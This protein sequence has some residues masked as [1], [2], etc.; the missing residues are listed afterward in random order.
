MRGLHVHPLM[1]TLTNTATPRRSYATNRVHY[2]PAPR[3]RI[4]PPSN[5][6]AWERPAPSVE[7]PVTLQWPGMAEDRQT[8]GAV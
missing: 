5:R 8:Q 1:G 6:R 4:A 3:A 2:H 7:H